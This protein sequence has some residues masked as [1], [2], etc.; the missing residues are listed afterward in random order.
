MLA[1]SDLDGDEYCVI[2]DRGLYFDANEA[3]FDYTSEPQMSDPV[4]DNTLVSTHI[5]EVSFKLATCRYF[6]Q[7]NDM[8]EFF[9]NYMSNDAIGKLANA[10]L[11][12]SDIYG[13]E[14]KVCLSV[15]KKHQAAVRNLKAARTQLSSFF[16]LV[17]RFSEN[18][19]IGAK[20]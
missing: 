5:V 13:I 16:S 15:A 14:H 1:G 8:I 11:I 2:W 3:A 19:R 20:A 4:D 17:G 6:L 7:K 10:F 9:V 18:R 12:D